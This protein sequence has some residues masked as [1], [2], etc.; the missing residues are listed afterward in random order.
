MDTI[1]ENIT[2][3]FYVLDRDWNFLTMNSVA[4]DV[5]GVKLETVE[6][7]SIWKFFPDSPN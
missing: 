6:G 1:I 4:E 7:Q 2:D 5:L 3:G